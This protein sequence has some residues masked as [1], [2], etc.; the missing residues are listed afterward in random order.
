MSKVDPPL[1]ARWVPPPI[2]GAEPEPE[3]E[4]ELGVIRPRNGTAS[5][6]ESSTMYLA[7]QTKE[8]RAAPMLAAAP[9]IIA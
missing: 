6:G 5:D 9:A 2:G 1:M 8:R 4:L 3:L 7:L